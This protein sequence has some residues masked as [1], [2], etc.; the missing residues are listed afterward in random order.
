M[1]CPDGQ[2]EWLETSPFGSFAFG[3]ID[4]KLRRKYHGLLTVREPGRG[5]AWSVLA[6][7]REYLVVDGQELLLCDPLTGG[8][9]AELVGFTAEPQARH[10]YR[11]RDIDVERTVRFGAADQL[12][13]RYRL[14]GITQP[15]TFEL[16]PL[17][18]CR[19]VHR[20]T[21]ENPF[22][23]GSFTRHRDELHMTPYA[24]MPSVAFR[25]DGCDVRLVRSGTWLNG[26]TY[27]V[28]AERGYE[29]RE[30]LFAPGR[31]VLEVA[32]DSDITLV[33]GL[34][35][36]APSVRERP[37]ATSTRLSFAQKLQ[38]AAGKFVMHTRA[39]TTALIAGYPW[40]G[41]W[42]RDTLIALPGIHLATGDFEQTAA[43]L[44]GMLDARINGL[45]P[46]IPALGDNAPDTSSIDASLLFTRAVQWLGQHVGPAHVERFMPA[47][48][49]LLEAIA[50]ARDRRMRLD[51]GLGVWMERG[52]WALTWM[53]A[54][55]DGQPVTPRAGYAV[56]VDALAYNAARFATEWASAHRPLFA[57][58]FRG[59]LRTAEADFMRRY[60]ADARGYLADAHDGQRQ[61]ASLRPNQLFAVGLPY[62]P[63]PRELAKSAL[64]AVTRELLVP[65]GLRTL[66]P[67]DPHYRGS[68]G[69]DQV[70]RDLAYHQGTAWPWLIGIY[71]DAVERVYGRAALET[72]LSTVFNFFARAIDA[73]GC[74]GQVAEI[75]AGDAPHTPNGAPAQAWSVAELYRALRMVHD[76]T[77]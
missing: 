38:R 60:W 45:I 8:S 3:C 35:R 12:E 57:R 7:L 76:R 55:I 9:E 21:F 73:E 16:E 49:E 10:H 4:R 74:V 77:S 18:R 36:L 31:F 27:P 61:D 28:E 75:Y 13:V 56:E 1:D 67:R 47:I 6:E 50:E 44:E 46:N 15:L 40:F 71:A 39:G 14:R 24:G 53:D 51:D 66:G 20:L 37:E 34:E 62:S 2:L 29:A 58:A 11:A 25:V 41:P 30:D 43:V 72:R 69:G 68:Y 32:R 22:L 52:P 19:D 54:M 42:G 64:E 48:C 23:D 70:A 63:I 33:V 65:C 5:D 59:R 17:L 26:V